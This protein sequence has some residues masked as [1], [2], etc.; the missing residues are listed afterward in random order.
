MNNNTNLSFPITFEVSQQRYPQSWQLPKKLSDKGLYFTSNKTICV[1][2]YTY[3]GS[4]DFEESSQNC[5]SGS[6]F[7]ETK[8]A[9]TEKLQL[10]TVRVSTRSSVN[11]SF[12]LLVRTLCPDILMNEITTVQ[13]TPTSLRL[14]HIHFPPE[15][16]TISSAVMVN[17]NSDDTRCAS[18]SVQEPIVSFL[19]RS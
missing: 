17:L 4:T 19:L 5:N 16:A 6:N 3:M 12:E 13:V 11:V 10:V 8:E 18:I 15:D 14:F 9:L 1:N 7:S 2:D